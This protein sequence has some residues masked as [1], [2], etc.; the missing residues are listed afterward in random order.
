MPRKNALSFGSFLWACK[1]KEQIKNA[2]NDLK[3]SYFNVKIVCLNIT[4]LKQ[5]ID[6]YYI[7]QVTINRTQKTLIFKRSS[8]YREVKRFVLRHD[9]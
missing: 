8:L 4:P 5:H 2:V 7:K 1:E 9:L 3:K 6:N